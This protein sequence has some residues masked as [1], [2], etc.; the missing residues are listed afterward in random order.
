MVLQNFSYTA[1]EL[2]SYLLS[3]DTFIVTLKNGR[4]VQYSPPSIASF[5]RWLIDNNVR[6]SRR[7]MHLTELFR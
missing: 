2:Q 6:D 4:V 7:Y 1:D 5:R 3:V